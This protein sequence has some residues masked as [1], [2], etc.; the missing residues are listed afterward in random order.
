VGRKR[1]KWLGRLSEGV[2]ILRSARTAALVLALTVAIWLVD[3][4]QIA[5][6]MAAV[7]FA[8][9][10]A[11]VALVLLFVNLTNALPATPGQLGVFEAGATAGCV[12]V[13]A[14]P[15]QGL[16]VGI[17]YHMMQFIPDTALGLAVLG[18]GALGRAAWRA[19]DATSV[20]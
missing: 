2:A 16:A 10:Y 8:P 15:E 4:A 5:L 14:T 17:L 6:A 1:G 9:S 18:R 7:S 19:T 11:G 20:R 12:A 3:L 13:G